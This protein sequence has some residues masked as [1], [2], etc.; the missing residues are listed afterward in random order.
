MNQRLLILG[1]GRCGQMTKEIAEAMGCFTQINFPDDQAP[2][3]VGKLL[4]YERFSTEYGYTI[5]ALESGTQRLKW[6]RKLEESC[7]QIPVLLHP[8][9]Y[10][11]PSAQL[12]KGTIV[13]PMAVVQTNT[14]V[15][16]SCLLSAGAVVEQNCF[17][18]D[19]CHIGCN[20]SVPAGTILPAQTKVICSCVYQPM[21]L[22]EDAELYV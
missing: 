1:A 11:S 14:T 10:V 9:A 6:I 15:A 5:P 3:A 4:D 8:R 22:Q 21:S 2:G 12:M 17:I 13:E 18:G 16:I 20:A 19:G 7:Y